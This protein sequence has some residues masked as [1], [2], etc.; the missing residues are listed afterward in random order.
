MVG[1]HDASFIDSSDSV[2][3]NEIIG[4]CIAN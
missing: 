4:F 3:L 2:I 1:D